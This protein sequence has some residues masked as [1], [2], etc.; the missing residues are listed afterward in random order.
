MG[1][2]LLV[3]ISVDGGHY[4]IERYVKYFSCGFEGVL[5]VLL[6]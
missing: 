5:N 1:S 6:L 4:D 3:Q 2:S